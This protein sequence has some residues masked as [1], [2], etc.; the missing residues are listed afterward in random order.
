MTGALE[1]HQAAPPPRWATWAAYATVLTT[2]PSGLWRIALALGLPFG[3]SEEAL[4]A[5]DTPGW[6]SLY[7]VALAALTTGAALLTLGLVQRWGETVPRWIPRIG[8]RAVPPRAAIIPATAGAV[9][10]TALWSQLLWWWSIDREHGMSDPTWED[11]V[12]FLYLPMVAW[13]PMLGVVT[14]SYARRRRAKTLPPPG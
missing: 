11:A 4:A 7:P 5:D 1:M 14:L 6:G 8:G 2:V 9:L 3:Y 10:L 12:G 13:G